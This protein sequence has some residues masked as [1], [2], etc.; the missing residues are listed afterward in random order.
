MH[1]RPSHGWPL[2]RALRATLAEGYSAARLRADVLAGIS[3]GLVALPLSLALAI[4]T[5][6]PPQHGLYTAIVAGAI[7]A[8]LGGSRGQVSGPTAAFVVVLAPIVRDHGVG[9]LCLATAMAGLALVAMGFLRLGRM[10]NLVPQPVTRGFTLGIAIVIAVGQIPDLLGVSSA[11][12]DAHPIPRIVG[13]VDRLGETATADVTLAFLTLALLALWPRALS[14]IPAPLG[15]L[16]IASLAGLALRAA[17]PDWEFHRLGDRFQWIDASGA[18]RPGIPPDLPAF[19]LPWNL[20]GADGAALAPDLALFRALLP[21]AATIAMLGAIESLLSATVA[22]GMSGGRHDPDGELVGQGL[23]NIVAPFFGGFAATGAIARTAT[24]LRAG[25]TSPVA[26]IVHAGFVALSMVLLAPWLSHLPMASLAAL[27]V[28]IAARMSDFRHVVAIV[29][30]SPG[31]DVGVLVTC[32][33]LTVAFDMVAAVVVG[34]GLASLLFMR[35]MAEISGAQ[36]VTPRDLDLE[37]EVP[38]G[39]LLY[40]VA[41]PLFFGA[42]DKAMGA[43]RVARNETRVVVLLLRAVPAIDATGIVNLKSAVAR[44]RAAGRPVILAGLPDQPRQALRRARLDEVP[45][46]IEFTPGLRAALARAAELA[47]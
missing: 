38:E 12:L 32:V 27:L 24:N 41:G 28:F 47:A 25:A 30:E 21:S 6:V 7:C 36:I 39:V 13:L 44:V 45:G 34:V 2:A 40:E 1:D 37:H 20:P 16:A 3:V 17:F 19:V 8:A 31:H 15:A 10:V 42:A 9:G 23:G 29:R 33:V 18:T 26:A 11:G 43:V 4:A 5:G 22:D 14:R 46:E 35:R